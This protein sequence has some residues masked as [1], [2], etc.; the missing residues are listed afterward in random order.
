MAENGEA[1]C[2]PLHFLRRNGQGTPIY[3]IGSAALFV[4]ALLSMH[5]EMWS[6]SSYTEYTSFRES[7][8]AKTALSG[9]NESSV[10]SRPWIRQH[11]FGFELYANCKQLRLPGRTAYVVIYDLF[12]PVSKLERRRKMHVRVFEQIR[13]T[14]TTA[15]LILI[16][17]LLND[18]KARVLQQGMAELG[19]QIV[20]RQ[21]P[22][23][24][25]DLPA[26]LQFYLRDN[27]NCCG[28]REF[29]KL[30][31]WTLT[32]YERVM[33][34]DSDLQFIGNVD[35]LLQCT[36]DVF[37]AS[38]GFQSPLNGGMWVLEPSMQTY[39]DMIE[40]LTGSTAHVYTNELHWGNFG[41]QRYHVGAEGPQG[42]MLY[43]FF[44]LPPVATPAKVLT[45][46]SGDGKG[47]SRVARGR[48]AYVDKC[49]YNANLLYCRRDNLL[50]ERMFIV[51]KPTALL[52]PAVRTPLRRCRPSVSSDGNE[53]TCSIIAPC[54]CDGGSNQNRTADGGDPGVTV[55]AR[56]LVVAFLAGHSG[57]E[58]SLAC[59]LVAGVMGNASVSPTVVATVLGRSHD[60]VHRNTR[61]DTAPQAPATVHPHTANALHVS[62]S[63]AE[64]YA[65]AGG[66]AW[67]PVDTPRGGQKEVASSARAYLVLV[68]HPYDFVVDA[69]HRGDAATLGANGAFA[70]LVRNGSASIE[71]YIAFSAHDHVLNPQ[72][73]RL[74]SV[75]R[76]RKVTNSDAKIAVSRLLGQRM[77]VG[78]ADMLPETLQ[79]WER[80]LKLSLFSVAHTDAGKHRSYVGCAHGTT[81]EEHNGSS[82]SPRSA[83][84]R[85]RPSPLLSSR[86]ARAAHV[87][88]IERR[89][90]KDM[91]LY[92]AARAYFRQ[93]YFHHFGTVLNGSSFVA[94]GACTEAVACA[95]S[96]TAHGEGI[97]AS[98]GRVIGQ[99]KETVDGST[100]GHRGTSPRAYFRSVVDAKGMCLLRCAA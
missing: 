75:P 51:H 24:Q 63:F 65:G 81:P 47:V 41:L 82:M 89:H 77:H 45:H 96:S 27:A 13:A 74:A 3:W 94:N 62:T 26:L 46:S 5:L 67:T 54:G 93:R 1:S 38:P 32:Q 4:L 99:T 100:H 97:T 19:V 83:R 30:T 61:A 86:T 21:M 60:D 7:I 52:T 91:V 31:A 80:A 11:S 20:Q 48:G 36:P 14:N 90:A 15:D 56:A 50:P 17:P 53:P 57:A 88:A 73:A 12:E 70:A 92:G 9:E 98:E 87:K 55:G 22:F 69:L 44:I 2:T 37:L 85:T 34:L 28:W 6:P 79:L 35:H 76:I 16:L 64:L 29:Y 95:K 49:V 71:D 40:M 58:V 72:T 33:M 39:Q 68:H 43:Y 18:P 42:F 84:G 23:A 25:Q 78:L 8:N 66:Y 10:L 59:T